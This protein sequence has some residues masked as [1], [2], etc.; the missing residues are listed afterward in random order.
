MP[1]LD[2]TSGS[3]R[4]PDPATP[5]NLEAKRMPIPGM[6]TA[7]ITHVLVV[8]YR[9]RSGQSKRKSRKFNTSVFMK[10]DTQALRVQMAGTAEVARDAMVS[11]ASP[12]EGLT[13]P[14]GI[15]ML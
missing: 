2:T 10:L 15:D 3:Y 13:Q 1:S 5:A 8:A 6:L 14:P 9:F 4:K 12:G 7:I 11:S